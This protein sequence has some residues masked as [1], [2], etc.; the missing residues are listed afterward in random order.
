MSQSDPLTLINP[1]VA[2]RE[3]AGLTR[4][5]LAVY[6]G[7]SV[8]GLADYE[9]GYRARIRPGLRGALERAGIPYWALAS[10]YADWMQARAEAHLAGRLV[11]NES[12]RDGI[13]AYLRLQDCTIE[14]EERE[15]IQTEHLHEGPIPEFPGILAGIDTLMPKPPQS[16]PDKI[17][18]LGRRIADLTELRMDL[19]RQRMNVQ[20]ELV[21]AR[22]QFLDLAGMSGEVA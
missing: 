1:L 15:A 14:R 8:S 16:V 4:E 5:Q 9:R 20:I 21:E 3:A 10:D 12:E 6:L 19:E 13:V 7:M 2:L 17:A 11:L 18:E 22:R